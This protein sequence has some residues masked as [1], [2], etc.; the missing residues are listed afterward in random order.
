MSEVNKVPQ[1]RFCPAVSLLSFLLLAPG[2][3]LSGE[4]V[5]RLTADEIA[6][7]W[8]LLFDETGVESWRGFRGSRFPHH[9][10]VLQ[11]GCLKNLASPRKKSF[12]SSI[13]RP[14]K[15]SLAGRRRRHLITLDRYQEFD[16]RFQWRIASGGNSGVKYFVLEERKKAIGPEYQIIDRS[17]PDWPPDKNTAAFYDVVPV[18]N[19]AIRSAEFNQGRVVVCGD[20]AEHWLN[21]EKVLEYRFGSD[22]LKAAIQESKFHDVPGFGERTRGHLVLQD[23]GDIVWFRNLKILDLSGRCQSE[24]GE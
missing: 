24:A 6:E 4:S 8:Q 7:G 15:N 13:A 12:L 5:N 14:I 11:D 3:E 18:S 23:H 1:S 9:S 21:G 10:W 22:E 2:T 16:F 17:G 20:R 19:N